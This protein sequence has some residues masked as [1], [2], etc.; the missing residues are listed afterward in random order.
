MGVT[1]ERLPNQLARSR[2]ANSQTRVFMA[3]VYSVTFILAALAIHQVVSLVMSWSQNKLDDLHYGRP[4]TMHL[5][6]IV[7]HEDAE[8]RPTHFIALNLDRQVVV[9]E[10][11]GGDASKVRSLP[12]PYL[13]GDNQ[14]LTPVILSLRDVDHDGHPDLLINVRNEQ[15]VYL[16]KEGAFRLPT[17]DEQAQLIQEQGP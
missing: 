3:F 8:G 16:N 4:R 10:L 11:P 5:Q 7:G 1:S 12:G 14:E 13:F 9:L 17:A 2:A 6:G 15:I